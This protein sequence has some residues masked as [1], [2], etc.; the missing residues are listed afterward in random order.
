SR[1]GGT[2]G[3]AS[4]SYSTSDGTATAGSDY[5]TISGTLN[6]TNGDAADKFFD[7]LIINLSRGLDH[8][9]PL[10]LR[11]LMLNNALFSCGY[12]WE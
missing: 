7:V 8:R 6:W 4:V 9:R 3:A 5:T 1:T 10:G 12:A 2:Y 11:S